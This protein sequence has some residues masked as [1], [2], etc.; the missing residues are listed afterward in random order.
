MAPCRLRNK[1]D[2]YMLVVDSFRYPSSEVHKLL[3]DHELVE[4]LWDSRSESFIES[5]LIESISALSSPINA[6]MAVKLFAALNNPAVSDTLFERCI[7]TLQLKFDAQSNIIKLASGKKHL[8]SE[9]VIRLVYEGFP[10][11]SDF[12]AS[13]PNT[14]ADILERLVVSESHQFESLAL[15]TALSSSIRGEIIRISFEKLRKE[16]YATFY[17]VM[18]R[19]A[20]SSILSECEIERIIDCQDARIC[21]LLLSQPYLPQKVVDALSGRPQGLWFESND[22]FIDNDF[23]LLDHFR[24]EWLKTG[25]L[26]HGQQLI[27]ASSDHSQQIALASN[28]NLSEEVIEILAKSTSIDV[29]HA[30]CI[31]VKFNK[32][33]KAL[34]DLIASCIDQ[35]CLFDLLKN[36]SFTDPDAWLT[37]YHRFVDEMN[38]IGAAYSLRGINSS[39]IIGSVIRNKQL[40]SLLELSFNPLLNAE[41]M[42]ALL[43]SL[44][45][46]NSVCEGDALV[47]IV[48]NISK[49]TNHNIASIGQ[50]I[51]FYACIKGALNV[52]TNVSRDIFNASVNLLR[53][54]ICPHYFGFLNT[55]NE[56]ECSFLCELNHLVHQILDH[57][58]D[59]LLISK[60]PFYH[61]VVALVEHENIFFGGDAKGLSILSK[62]QQ[63]CP[64]VGEMLL[65]RALTLRQEQISKDVVSVAAIKNRRQL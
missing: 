7:N 35:A 38:V 31:N 27:F 37:I 32:Y 42:I 41:Q 64:S 20:Q 29:Q 52:E 11:L 21:A 8:I 55:K 14:P 3:W 19:L 10:G 36:K 50:L 18:V 62:I 57:A 17:E 12:I 63:I 39:Q 56:G 26:S 15:N 60:S 13:C 53:K 30:L 22:C 45:A 54:V 28:N 5:Y 40:E 48:R 2:L 33:S 61:V 47:R 49:N 65:N 25:Y 23:T 34:S 58:S 46:L 16:S 1:V 6:S 59:D 4:Y 24:L 9:A 51:S 44:E 43:H